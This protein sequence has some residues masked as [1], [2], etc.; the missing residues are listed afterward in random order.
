MVSF[1]ESF[2]FD[3][4]TLE[5]NLD[6]FPQRVTTFVRNL[7][8]E[9]AA[10]G[11]RDMKIEAPWTETGLRNRWG[12]LSTGL[13]R[14]GLWA[15]SDTRSDGTVKITMGHT[16]KYGIYLEKAMGERFAIVEPILERTAESFM[17][18]L[19]AMFAEFEAH[20]EMHPVVVPGEVHTPRGVVG[21]AVSAESGRRVAVER[22]GK[23]EVHREVGGRGRFVSPKATVIPGSR[24][25]VTPKTKRTRRR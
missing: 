15:D 6:T 2:T 13:A 20:D 11:E 23:K 4:G 8:E 17:R 19:E 24:T 18:S 22:Y 3:P 10:A 16:A 7:A 5:Y 25:G 14:N 9:E 1:K 12:R 21:Y